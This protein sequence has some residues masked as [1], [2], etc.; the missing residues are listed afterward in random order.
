MHQVRELAGRRH[1]LTVLESKA[2]RTPG[3]ARA[4]IQ[5]QLSALRREI[6]RLETDLAGVAAREG[7]GSPPLRA[8]VGA[9]G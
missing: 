8:S 3:A 6:A 4:T 9:A 1:F 2:E 5:H 7:Q